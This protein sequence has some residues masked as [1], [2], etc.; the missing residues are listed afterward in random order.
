M[1]IARIWPG[2]PDRVPCGMFRLKDQWHVVTAMTTD[3]HGVITKLAACCGASTPGAAAWTN[4][5]TAQA[6][7]RR[8]CEA[9]AMTA[10]GNGPW[11]AP[12]MLPEHLM[13]K[14]RNQARDEGQ[15]L[16]ELVAEMISYRRRRNPMKIA[17]CRR[18]KRKG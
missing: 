16:E 15:P 12:V 13:E 11:T 7:G 9:C 5:A 10:V 3:E 8:V 4:L 17:A 14:L 2:T 6:R 18:G 1:R